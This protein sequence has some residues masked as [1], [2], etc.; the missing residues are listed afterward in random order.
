MP[1]TRIS[2]WCALE[3]TRTAAV[4][5]LVAGTDLHVHAGDRHRRA[6]EAAALG[7]TLGPSDLR[8]VGDAIAAAA[9]ARN[10]MREKPRSL[11][12]VAAYLR[13]CASCTAR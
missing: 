9:A 6:H 8:A 2:S 1:A 5:E 4:R 13:R 7:R 3:Q 12:R 10:A 11:R